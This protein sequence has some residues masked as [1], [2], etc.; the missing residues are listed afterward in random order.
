MDIE[1]IKNAGVELQNS[2]YYY[3]KK[4]TYT[5][6]TLFLSLGLEFFVILN[7]NPEK[8]EILSYIFL[9]LTVLV[10]FIIGLVYDNKTFKSIKTAGEYLREVE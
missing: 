4:I 2:Q 3:K 10:I 7:S 5:F 9:V 6:L 8:A 1:N